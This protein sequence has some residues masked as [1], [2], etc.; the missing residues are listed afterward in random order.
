MKSW[1]PKTRLRKNH[2]ERESPVSEESCEQ[3]HQE[4]MLVSSEMKI[5]LSCGDCM[6]DELIQAADGL[7]ALLWCTR[8]GQAVT[9]NPLPNWE[10]LVMF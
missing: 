1:G 7:Q 5:D 2:E 6:G 3:C 10:E 9:M 8:S 4:K